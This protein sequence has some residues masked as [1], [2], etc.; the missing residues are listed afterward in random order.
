[1]SSFFFFLFFFFLVFF[2]E[3]IS[4]Y[5]L[6]SFFSYLE[7]LSTFLFSFHYLNFFLYFILCAT[8]FILLNLVSESSSSSKLSYFSFTSSRVVT[9]KALLLLSLA[10]DSSP[11]FETLEFCPTLLFSSLFWFKLDSVD[12]VLIRLFFCSILFK[13]RAASTCLFFP[14]QTLATYSSISSSSASL[15]Y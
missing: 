1:M 5:Y 8:S 2:L 10:L 11:S 12:D 14:L 4:D 7:L 9:W 6:F 3:A 15:T 13:Y